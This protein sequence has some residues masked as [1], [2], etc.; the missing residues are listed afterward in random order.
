MME[1]KGGR[2]PSAG[3]DREVDAQLIDDEMKE[4]TE[5]QPLHIYKMNHNVIYTP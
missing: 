1:W 2:G 5:L 4:I 3:Y